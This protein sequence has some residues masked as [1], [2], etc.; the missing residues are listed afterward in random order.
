M[1]GLLGLLIEQYIIFLSH[2]HNNFWPQT[3]GSFEYFFSI[4]QPFFVMSMIWFNQISPELYSD[5]F[6]LY[7]SIDDDKKRNVRVVIII[8]IQSTKSWFLS[9]KIFL[10]DNGKYELASKIIMYFYVTYVL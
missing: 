6:L 3:F 1:I 7:E 4:I 5:A 8:F 9:L 10:S 2:L